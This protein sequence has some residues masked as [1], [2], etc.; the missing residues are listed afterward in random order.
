MR[1]SLRRRLFA[2][3]AVI[4]V[5]CIGLTLALG[6]L[7]TRKAVADATLQDVAHQAALIAERERVALQPFTYLKPL[8][9]YLAQQHETYL[10][11]AAQL[12]K[13]ARD[14]LRLGLA[15]QGSVTLRGT[16]YFFAAQPV[17]PK[18]PFVLLRPKS[19]TKSQW[20]PLLVSLV[21]AAVA[22]AL[23][24][25]IAAFFLASRIAG[26]VHRVAEAARTLARGTRPEPVAVTGAAEL[27][28]LALAFND[29]AEQLTRAQEAERSFLLS[30]SHEL[31]TPLT[32]I[33]GWAEALED[34]AVDVQDAAQTVAAESA[35]LER[36]VRDLL[37]LARMNRTD[38]SVHPSEIDLAEVAEDA[39][40]RYQQQAA[41]FGV[42]LTAFANGEAPAVADAD[43]ALQVVSNLVENALR[44]A[45]PGGEVRVI[46]APGLLRV[47][48]TGPG[49]QPEE[50][51][52]AFERFYLHER[53]GRER[54]VGTGLGLAIVKELTEA[55]GG[56]VEVVS[57]P[58]RLT[59]FTVMLPTRPVA[60]TVTAL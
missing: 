17:E 1:W 25:A 32:A 53:Y 48:D 36:L 30:V 33:R 16:A 5:L 34:G 60:A 13:H 41:A 11:S 28:T 7:L 46:T 39:V 15:A 42:S 35:R 12:P 6:L 23:L 51:D 8:Q 50:R 59:A 31:K 52:R 3:I 14:Q 40:R 21:I 56:R 44:L 22:G 49:L 47:E 10:T 20:T 55:M 19:A 43:R 24:A 9:P 26:P 27:A 38:F 2:A 58:G 57:E 54:P 18:H 4:V 37:D 45:P 29:L